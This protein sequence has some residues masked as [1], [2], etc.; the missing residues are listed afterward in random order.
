MTIGNKIEVFLLTCFIFVTPG[1]IIYLLIWGVSKVLNGKYPA[2][3]LKWL[4]V[5]IPTL[6]SASLAYILID[7]FTYTV[8]GFG[9]VSSVGIWRSFYAVLF[10]SLVV[11]F[12]LKILKFTQSSTNYSK[13]ISYLVLFFFFASGLAFVI[14]IP[15]TKLDEWRKIG[16]IS[17]NQPNI[18]LLGIDGVNAENMSVY[19]YE[20]ETTPN[21][22]AL[23]PSALIMENAFSN[24]GN[25][26][27]SLTSLLTGKLPTETRVV[28]P[29][30][31]L[32]GED[33]Y[34][35][36]PG[37]LK[38]LGYYT[39][40]VTMPSFGDAYDRNIK[41]GFDVSNF[42]SENENP[43]LTTFQKLG[44]ENG[45][46]F[47][48]LIVQRIT[49]RLKHAL[50]I[51]DMDNPYE[52]VTKPVAPISEDERFQAMLDYLDVSDDPLFLHVHM[53]G[54]HGPYFDP[55]E[56]VFSQGL[57]QDQPWMTDFYDD[58]IRDFDKYF[59]MLFKYLSKTGKIENTI[60]IL[61]SDHGMNW[62][63]RKKIPLIIWFPNHTY[64]GKIFENVQLLDVAPTILD[65]LGISQPVWMSG[66]SI[67]QN[68]L[69]SN[70]N[71][72]SANTSAEVVEN[73]EGKGWVVDES[74]I[75]PPFYQLSTVNLIVCKKWYSLD[76]R[77][78][79]LLYGDVS[80][81]TANCNEDDI[82]TPEQAQ[83]LI[84]VQL[85]DDGYDT[86]SYPDYIPITP[87][88]PLINKQ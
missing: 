77:N 12:F 7:N 26:G 29:P 59:N 28:Y 56:R 40:Q 78:P 25:T 51:E 4:G 73:I 21:I 42:R 64:S 41:F 48:T 39:V 44:G 18:V 71:I 52:I 22:T 6:V 70:R 43:F 38:R 60:I 74:V 33:A 85:T 82:P 79:S 84:L 8:F 1:I 20:R 75:S 54:T 58:A 53:M 19:G 37:I 61:Y 57:S 67:L 62:D 11:V 24:S 86:S 14:Q 45:L 47:S 16:N 66:K 50:Y 5:L 69:A 34:Q 30:D 10:A 88:G 27:G 68:D 23:S 76:L 80:D 72:I 17:S 46:Y 3:I 13:V 83:K 15:S 2:T 31:I 81:S 65:Y 9:I 87:D 63:A 36:L 49:D 35:H 32:L 55:R